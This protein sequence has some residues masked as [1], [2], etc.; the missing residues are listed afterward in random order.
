MLKDLYWNCTR[1]TTKHV[2]GNRRPEIYKAAPSL[3]QGYVRPMRWAVRAHAGGVSP[4]T[5]PLAT[6][7]GGA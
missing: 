6:D 5:L 7:A 3:P 1:D 4:L 2:N